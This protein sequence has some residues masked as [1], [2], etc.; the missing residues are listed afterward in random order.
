MLKWLF[1]FVGIISYESNKDESGM[2]NIQFLALVQRG[3]N[4]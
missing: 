2:M 4:S 1:M 3:C